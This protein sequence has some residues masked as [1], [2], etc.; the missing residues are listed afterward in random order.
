MPLPTALFFLLQPTANKNL[1]IWSTPKQRLLQ[2]YIYH[3]TVLF[4][5]IE[6]FKQLR[7]LRHCPTVLFFSIRPSPWRRHLTRTNH[8]HGKSN[9][10][11]MLGFLKALSRNHSSTN[12]QMKF[13]RINYNKLQL[14]TIIPFVWHRYFFHIPGASESPRQFECSFE[15]SNCFVMTD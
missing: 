10:M 12:E 9:N 8:N 1:H 13:C 11:F 5:I 6:N 7:L 4:V 3:E 15:R 2:T 14:N